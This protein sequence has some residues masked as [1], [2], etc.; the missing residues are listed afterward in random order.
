MRQV[1]IST[2]RMKVKGE[3]VIF[4]YPNVVAKRLESPDSEAKTAML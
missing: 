3:V 4:G 1:K 2:V